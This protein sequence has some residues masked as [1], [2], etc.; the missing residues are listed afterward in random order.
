MILAETFNRT[1]ISSAGNSNFLMRQQS[2]ILQTDPGYNTKLCFH[3]RNKV[4]LPI[5]WGMAGDVLRFL[6][7]NNT[8]MPIAWKMDGDMPYIHILV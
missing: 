3:Q 1:R 5:A 4:L 8:L 6:Q 2:I 7:R